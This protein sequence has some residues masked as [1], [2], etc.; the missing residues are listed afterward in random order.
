MVMLSQ[1]ELDDI[2][3]DVE[4]LT[5]AG[6]AIISRATEVNDGYGDLIKTWA[7]V[8]TAMCRIDP[9]EA[10]SGSSVGVIAA[11]EKGKAYYRFTTMWDTDIAD[12]DRIVSGGVTY[13]MVQLHENHD[14]R[15]VKRAIL[16]KI[17]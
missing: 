9:I 2:R 17:G 16:A 14:L 15:A 11:Q 6:T 3:T 8:G 10:Q 1:R 12:G 13:E 7:N 5:L 4:T